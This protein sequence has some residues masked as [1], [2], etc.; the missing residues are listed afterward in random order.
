MQFEKVETFQDSTRE[1][2]RHKTESLL[3]LKENDTQ[4]TEE[5]AERLLLEME[6]NLLLAVSVQAGQIHVR[7]RSRSS[8]IRALEMLEF[9]C[10]QYGIVSGDAKW[11]QGSISEVLVSVQATKLEMSDVTEY[12]MSRVDEYVSGCDVIWAETFA[13]D[14]PKRVEEMKEYQKA[15]APWA[16]VRTV[17][18]VPAGVPIRIRTLENDTGIIVESGENVYVMIGCLGEVYQIQR[19]KFESSYEMSDEKLDIFEQY[20]EFIP[21]VER[22]EDGVHIAI[23]EKAR[24]CYPKKEASILAQPLK[25]RSKVFAKNSQ[26]YFV[27]MQGDYLAIKKEDL[28]D[29][30]IIREEV[31]RRTY[32]E[33][34]KE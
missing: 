22:V 28:Q 4:L 18:I 33:K 9:V 16:C 11:A 3:L 31:F 10:E 1:L 15:D 2:F 20:M 5:Q 26:D 14:F 27:G 24:I 12:V 34:G 32:E 19:E 17:D 6:E 29:L 8:Y 25:R 23:D 30:Y 7:C 21:Y 13:K